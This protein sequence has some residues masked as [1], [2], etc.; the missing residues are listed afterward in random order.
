MFVHRWVR[1]VVIHEAKVTG[2]LLVQNTHIISTVLPVQSYW[3]SANFLC[4]SCL[5]SR[6]L[7]PPHSLEEHA[8]SVAETAAV[9]VPVAAELPNT[10]ERT[11][12]DAFFSR[13]QKITVVGITWH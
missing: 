4:N 7:Q 1:G 11:R 12:K 9:V 2:K 3:V 8:A 13:Y 5:A 6:R 10:C